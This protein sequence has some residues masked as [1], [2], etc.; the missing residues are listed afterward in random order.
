MK[1]ANNDKILLTYYQSKLLFVSFLQDLLPTILEKPLVHVYALS[2][3]SKNKDFALY[4]KDPNSLTSTDPNFLSIKF[5]APSRIARETFLIVLGVSRYSGLISGLDTKT[6]L[7]PH[8]PESNTAIELIH[9]SNTLLGVNSG[10]EDKHNAMP[11]NEG[12]EEEQIATNIEEV[13][14]ELKCMSKCTAVK[15]LEKQPVESRTTLEVKSP[16]CSK[17]LAIESELEEDM[18]LLRHKLECKNKV[19]TDLREELNTSKE[20]N[21]KGKTEFEECSRSLRLA[22]KRIE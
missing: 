20:T 9:D 3:P 21:R 22:D 8:V 17:M 11:S 5:Q 10:D 19:V 7:F 18:D 6:L 13:D 16:F 4:L 1:A 12:G 14:G 15:N 2:N